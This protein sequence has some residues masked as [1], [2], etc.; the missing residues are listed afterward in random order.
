M[1]PTFAQR[2]RKAIVAGVSAAG[3]AAVTALVTGG[4]LP[5]TDGGWA[6]LVSGAIAA[7]LAAAWATYRTKNAHDT[8]TTTTRRV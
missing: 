5:N 3:T 8:A 1:R 7:G 4:G 2:A 6:A